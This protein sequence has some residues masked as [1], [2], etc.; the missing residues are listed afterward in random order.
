MITK[1]TADRIFNEG[2]NG[3][4]SEMSSGIYH[5][6][7]LSH[8]FLVSGADIQTKQFELMGKASDGF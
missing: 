5:G 7:T 1:E 6:S 2:M 8:S 4:I 3:L